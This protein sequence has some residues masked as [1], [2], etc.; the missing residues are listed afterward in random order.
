MTISR[1]RL[2]AVAGF[3][4]FFVAMAVATMLQPEQYSSVR[5]F[6]SGLAAV[7]AAH[8]EV[9]IAGFQAAAVAY[10]AIAILAWRTLRSVPGRLTAFL[11][12]V[13]AVAISVA[14]FAQFDCSLNL[15]SCTTGLDER[16]SWHSHLHGRAGTFVFFST[17]VASFTLALAVW[18]SR[19]RGRARL[20]AT[21]LAFAIVQLALTVAMNLQLLGWT[22]VYQRLDVALMQGLPLLVV[23]GLRPFD[24]ALPEPLSGRDRVTGVAATSL[25]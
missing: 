25:N 7:D 15:P 17:L 23:S 21:V 1:L 18:R 10:L 16:M 20:G 13:A 8:P 3:A 12:L 11:L 19:F 2:T 4:G 6:I 14:G 24:A 9:M 22:G 5:D